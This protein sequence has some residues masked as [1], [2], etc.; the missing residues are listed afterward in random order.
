MAEFIPKQYKKEVVTIR[1]ETEKLK[2]VDGYAAQYEISRS[3]FINQCI[4]FSIKN[5]HK[6]N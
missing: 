5:M 3:D 1:I 4:D 2:T 6:E